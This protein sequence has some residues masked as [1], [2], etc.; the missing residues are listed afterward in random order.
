MR[1]GVVG[2]L[3]GA[4][5]GFVRSLVLAGL[6]LLLPALSAV[7]AVV[8]W[9]TGSPWS[10]TNP[11][12][13]FGFL[14]L[15]G[16]LALVLA[17]PVSRAVRRLVL[18]WTGV[19]IEGGYRTPEAEPEPVQLSTGFWWNG[20]GYERSRRDAELDQQW[21]RRIG[22]PAYWRD[23]RWLAI[24]M[25]TIG[26]LCAVPATALAAG[27]VLV[28]RGSAAGIA[29][30]VL[31]LL[32]AIGTAPYV[33]RILVPL[34]DRWLRRSGHSA[35]SERV[36]ELTTQRAEVTAAQAAEI[37]RIER[38]LHDGAQARLVAMGLSLA[39]VEKLI[40]Q[41]P[42][43]AKELLREA[44]AGASTSLA[45]L[46][47]LVRG[48]NP[49]VLAERGLPDAVRAIALDSGMDVTVDAPAE[50]RLSAPIESAVY[51]SVAELIANAGK[52]AGSA[53]VQVRISDPGRD[54]GSVLVAEVDDHGPGGA[55]IMPGGGLDGVRR[56]LAAFDGTL[57][58]DSPPGGPTHARIEVPCASS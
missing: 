36:R 19:R 7:P 40:D 21:R 39:A 1:T 42:E 33:W 54:H 32:V 27:V 5:I 26:P 14:M 55:V 45:E 18:R 52:Y 2:R 41:Q 43:R 57:T 4:G 48:L 50:L 16:P 8:G 30:G 47:D 24:A 13:W 29:I 12:T 46:R 23:V 53:P 15:A 51:F 49:P 3:R 37:R 22:D 11:W 56:R 35:M 17:R 38:D 6:A 44:R 9:L 28:V 34:A 20:H 25:I 10:A 58:I 31:L